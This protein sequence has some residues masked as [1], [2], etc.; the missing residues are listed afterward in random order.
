MIKTVLDR[1]AAL[2]YIEV[3]R[4]LHGESQFR[5]EPYDEAKIM[6]LFEATL[7]SPSTHYIA[8]DSEY[9][10]MIIMGINEHYFSRVKWAADYCLFIVPEARGGS[11]VVRLIE[12]A[13]NWA[14]SQ[15]ASWIRIDHNT[16]ISPE[17]APTL[18]N[19]L[20]FDLAGYIFTKE[21]K[22]VRN[23]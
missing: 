15:G 5:D 9:R 14:Y 18:F 11:L 4:R 3:G 22:D 2:K 8:Y 19:K 23:S 20:G 12:A 17:K 1:E 13:S 16:G 10:G 7:V 6:A 21:L